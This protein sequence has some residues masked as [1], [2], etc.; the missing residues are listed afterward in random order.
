MS[1]ERDDLHCDIGATSSLLIGSRC[2]KLCFQRRRST[3][4]QRL[5]AA[6]LNVLNGNVD[7]QTTEFNGSE[8]SVVTGRVDNINRTSAFVC[9]VF[10]GRWNDY[11][12]RS[13]LPSARAENETGLMID[14]GRPSTVFNTTISYVIVFC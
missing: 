5:V 12:V 2:R 9:S 7:G 13:V 11:D 14:A 1:S 10:R 6:F 4:I 3:T 8:T